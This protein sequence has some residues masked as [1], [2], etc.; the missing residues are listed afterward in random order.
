MKLTKRHESIIKIVQEFEPI[1]SDEIADKL[2]LGKSTLRNDLAVLGMLE[3][4]EAK[5]NVGYYYNY[6]FSYNAEKEKI[7]DKLV[8]DVMSIA[9]TAKST[10]S[11]SEVLAKLFIHDVGTIFVVNEDNYLVGVTSRKDMLKLA[12][13]SE[14]ESLPIALAMTRI[15]N[16]ITIG[17]NDLVID[18]LHKIISHEIDCLPVVKKENGGNMVV[19]KI[20]K[21]TLIKLLLEILEG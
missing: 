10:D 16:V 13:N 15:P 14:A 17:E 19:G 7:K 8:S 3:I 2:S 9:I 5:P 6:N 4:L 12:K 20:S 11:Y 18:A 1:T 21:T